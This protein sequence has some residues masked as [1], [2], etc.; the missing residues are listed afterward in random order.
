[1]D[2]LLA[3]KNAHKI[4]EMNRIL[5]PLDVRVLGEHECGVLLPDVEET[6]G[7]FAENA[8]LKARLAC[9]A[10]GMPSIADDSGLC[11]DGLDG[12]PGVLSARFAGED[13]DDQRNIDKL[14]YLLSDAPEG[15][16]ARNARFVC[17][18]CCCFPDGNVITA[19]GVCRGVIATC[20][21]GDNGFGYDPVF[22]VGNLSFAQMESDDKDA[23]SHRG[24][25][26]RAFSEK[27]KKRIGERDAD[28]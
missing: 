3:T 9:L 4:E 18:I 22:M 17:E 2:F 20:R 26:L 23:V 10:S 24:R 13:H 19:Q 25:A 5:A 8:F 27:L 6:G 28:Q 12:A 21:H 7:T 15:D 16:P 11:V 1:M 14:L